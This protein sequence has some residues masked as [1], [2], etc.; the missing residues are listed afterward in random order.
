MVVGSGRGEAD[1]W[2][3]GLA[4]GLATLAAYALFARYVPGPFGNPDAE[5]GADLPAGLGRLS[6]PIGYWNGL[7]AAMAAAIVLLGWLGGRGET[8]LGRSLAV[9]MLPIAVLALWATDSRGGFIT[10][11]LACAVLIGV[12]PSRSATLAGL[13]IGGVGGLVA[14]IAAQGFDALF[15]RPGSD[16]GGQ[17][18]EMLTLTILIAA[19]TG[20]AR[21]WADRP[22]GELAVPAALGKR[23]AIGA[24]VL[25]VVAIVVSDPVQRFDEFKSV[26]QGTEVTAGSGLLRSGSSGRWQFWNTAVDGYASAPV[27]GLGAGGYAPYWIEHREIALPATRAHSLLLETL[28]ELGIVGLA[29][30]V[31]FFA[32]PALAA[33]GRLREPGRVA[34]LAPAL[35][36]LA[37]GF[38]V[39]S[40]DWIWDLPG[41]FVATVI[42]AALLS[43]PATLPPGPRGGP[44][45]V[46]GT[47]RSRRRFSG[48]VAVLIGAWVAIC[49]CGLLL[50]ANHSVDAGRD[51]LGRGR[52]DDAVSSAN[53]AIDLEPWAAEPRELLALAEER[54]GDI[55]AARRAVD[56][57]IER[58]EDDYQLWLLRSRLAERAGDE[59]DARNSLLHAHQL[60]PLDPE[61]Q[62]LLEENGLAPAGQSSDSTV[63][64]SG[65]R[66]S[67]QA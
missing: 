14:V 11:L 25:A 10:A 21:W 4:I 32:V 12:G 29:L 38:A 18:G 66:W 36:V 63:G 8:R 28:A 62:S 7:A 44:G 22:V 46:Q 47:V 54:A 40:V 17:G 56:E 61:I 2:L 37:V 34:E 48:G 53:N 41:V 31:A 59:S 55:P 67:N 64:S 52:V 39:A 24:A 20:A 45:V 30:V 43:G 27:G 57:A 35:G 49:A 60:N 5:L 16:L 65:S 26:P 50:L 13:A 6:Y 23:A 3:R 15:Q 51:Q 58:A 1:I 9:G 42:A 19:A 33:T